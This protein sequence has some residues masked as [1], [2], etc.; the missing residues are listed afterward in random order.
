MWNLT[1]RDE[2]PFSG[3]FIFVSLLMVIIA[4]YMLR[5]FS[6]LNWLSPWLLPAAVSYWGLFRPR[7]TPHLIIFLL[8]LLEDGLAGVPFG[9]H[10][11]GLLVLFQLTLY[12]RHYLEHNP[13]PMIWTAFTLNMMAVYGVMTL[14]MWLIGVPVTP[15]V[16]GAWLAG[17][18]SFPV[19]FMLMGLLHQALLKE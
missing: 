9:L 5:G 13:F 10:S 1:N 8:G 7:Y 11:S 4:S 16:V 3:L 2:Q 12:Q 17:V 14:L 18:A 15:W 19:V 6:G